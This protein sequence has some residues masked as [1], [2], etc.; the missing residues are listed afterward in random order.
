M[1]GAAPSVHRKARYALEAVWSI[2][3]AAAQIASSH[4]N[5]E[6]AAPSANTFSL[7]GNENLRNVA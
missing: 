1:S 5:K 6:L 2:A 3:I 7:K 4:A